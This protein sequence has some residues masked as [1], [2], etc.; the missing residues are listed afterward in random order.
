MS[1]S[2]AVQ[3]A[4]K[5]MQLARLKE[6]KDNLKGYPEFYAKQPAQVERA[7]INQIYKDAQA[8]LRAS[9]EVLE[10]AIITGEGL[11]IVGRLQ[12]SPRNIFSQAPGPKK[13]ILFAV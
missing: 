5:K 12:Q 3:A 13:N 9:N 4:K 10:V 7:R 8:S 2:P 6:K 1:V 11:E